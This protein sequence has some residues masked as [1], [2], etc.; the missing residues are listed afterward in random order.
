MALTLH[1][2]PANGQ[3]VPPPLAAWESPAQLVFATAQQLREAAD[4]QGLRELLC[5]GPEALFPG[6]TPGR[7]VFG[8][9]AEELVW[10]MASEL[11]AEPDDARS[12]PAGFRLLCFLTFW[13]LTLNEQGAFLELVGT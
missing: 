6:C 10:E 7:A 2:R 13:R 1:Y 12:W 3:S 11:T 5:D 9:D 8:A 4:A